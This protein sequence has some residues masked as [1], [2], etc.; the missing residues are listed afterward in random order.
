MEGQIPQ[1][2]WY[3]FSAA[4]F[5]LFLIDMWSHRHTHG[6]GPEARRNAIWWSVIWVSAGLGF[7]F[8]IW[9]MFSHQAAQEY[10]AAYLIEKSLSLD[11]LFVFL[12]IFK[13]LG[14]PKKRQHRVLFWGIFG[15]L[16]FRGLFIYL[17]AAALREFTWISYV[18]GVILLFA[19]WHTFREDPS[20]KEGSGLAE[21]LETHL[22][23]TST[24]HGK[25]FWVVENGARVLTPLAVA[26]VAIELSDIMFAID[27]VPAALAMTKNVFIVYS[28]NVFAIL[29]LRALYLVLAHTIAELKYLHYGLAAV[30]GFAGIKIILSTS[31]THFPP[32]LSV[33]IIAVCIGASVVASLWA[34][35]DA[36]PPEELL[37]EEERE[38]VNT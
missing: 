36:P 22:P 35:D 12:I 8:F 2:G 29:G 14:I 16:V 31:N 27:S 33:G 23:V 15:A 21:W 11:N 25:K 17:G 24:L 37:P 34:R 3:V 20:E 32:M 28:S 5:V 18:F 38:P 19:A 9:E 10:L 26:L 6:E 7:G 13:T 30:L 1:W 4:V